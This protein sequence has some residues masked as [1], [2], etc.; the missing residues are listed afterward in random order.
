M[1][2]HH[3]IA[4]LDADVLVPILSCDLLLS[5][6]E[7]DVYQPVVTPKI[8]GEVEHTLIDDF[9]QFDPATL[10]RRAAQIAEALKYHTIPDP[11]IPATVKATVN[12]KDHHVAAAGVTAKANL[13]VTND[14]RLR[15]E[16]NQLGQ[17]LRA[18]A[19]DDFMVA[20]DADKPA[21]IDQAPGSMIAKRV[22]RPV[23][24]AELLDQLAPAFPKFADQAKRRQEQA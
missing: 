13:I 6:F 8:L 20:L 10:V 9:P 22:R 1:P 21:D 7:Q 2:S 16:A 5:T 4:V 12:A 17:G 19:A 3:V 14:K 18:V 23:T 15:R 24:R 11:R